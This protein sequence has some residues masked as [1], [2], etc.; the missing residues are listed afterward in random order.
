MP[1]IVF[2]YNKD[3]VLDLTDLKEQ[4]FVLAEEP[5]PISSP[6]AGRNGDHDISIFVMP[7]NSRIRASLG[8]I[9][10]IQRKNRRNMRPGRKG[11]GIFFNTRST[12]CAKMQE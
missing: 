3:R 6:K 8:S 9:L 7:H 5:D 12:K 2:L 1:E 4:D 10:V 11:G